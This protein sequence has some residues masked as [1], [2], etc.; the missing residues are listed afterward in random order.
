MS[1]QQPVIEIMEETDSDYVNDQLAVGFELLAVRAN[2][3][4]SVEPFTFVL[5]R[6]RGQK[7]FIP[8][9]PPRYWVDMTAEQAERADE[10][11]KEWQFRFNQRKHEY[12]QS[13]RLG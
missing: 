6:R 2:G 13:Q 1:E 9:K 5:A 11:W 4:E 3:E 8:R 7:R 12:Q 10:D